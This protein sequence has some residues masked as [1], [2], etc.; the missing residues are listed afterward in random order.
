[1]TKVV[2]QVYYFETAPL[3]VR[4]LPLPA[5]TITN[6]QENF[7]YYLTLLHFHVFS[8]RIKRPKCFK[9]GPETSVKRTT[10]E[11]GTRLRCFF[12]TRRPTHALFIHQL[13]KT[14]LSSG[15]AVIV[16]PS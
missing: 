11:L 13:V 4:L 14:P 16:E 5:A 1:M 2:N 9:L 15:I 7:A 3:T 12:K 8:N 6:F 10:R